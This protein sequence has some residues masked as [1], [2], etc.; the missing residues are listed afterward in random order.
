MA[1]SLAQ[2]Y[3]HIVF[4][5]KNRA[6][7]INPEIEVEL[8]AYMGNNIKRLKGIP[9][10]I[11]GTTDHIHVFSTLPRTVSLAKFIEDIKRNSSRWIKSK[12]PRYEE[13]FW[14]DGY[15]AFS[16][17][18]SGKNAV[19]KY[20]ANQK[21]HHKTNSFKDEFLAF[22]DKYEIEYDEKYLWD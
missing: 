3:T 2:M 8:F 6:P 16:V 11:N 5:T 10:L 22:L 1:Q 18:A 9:F 12:D 4:S 20:I 7:L 13:F 14:Q 17:S 21:I 19:I 15:G